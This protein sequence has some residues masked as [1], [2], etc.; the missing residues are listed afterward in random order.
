MLTLES[1]LCSPL[2][3]P[4]SV[5]PEWPKG[6]G[7]KSWVPATNVGDADGVPNFLLQPGLAR[8]VFAISGMN[9]Q[10]GNFSACFSLWLSNNMKIN[11]KLSKNKSKKKKKK[12]PPNFS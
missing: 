9:Q 10:M 12:S 8:D 3:L 7:P 6:D 1:Q 2:Q 5:D 11:T 4:A